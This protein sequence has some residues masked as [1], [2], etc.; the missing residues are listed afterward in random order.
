MTITA[1]TLD[2]LCDPLRIH[3][4]APGGEPITFIRVMMPVIFGRLFVVRSL[5][6]LHDGCNEVVCFI[7]VGSCSLQEEQML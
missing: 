1:S 5:D 6:C 7:E 4:P 3:F 2:V